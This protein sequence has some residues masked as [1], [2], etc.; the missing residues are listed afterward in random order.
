MSIW[1]PPISMWNYI[2]ID[3]LTFNICIFDNK[4]F[5]VLMNSYNNLLLFWPS[6]SMFQ[7]FM[8]TY[9]LSSVPSSFVPSVFLRASIF[10]L[11]SSSQTAAHCLEIEHGRFLPRPLQ[12][13]VIR[14]RVTYLIGKASLLLLPLLVT[15]T[16]WYRTKRPMHCGHFV[17]Y[18][19]AS[20]EF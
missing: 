4:Y 2:S 16:G 5:F 17:I 20:F 7:Q 12:P 8:I 18:C 15:V 3:I 9:R 13:S 10:P 11:S 6:G 19:A 14:H 1:P